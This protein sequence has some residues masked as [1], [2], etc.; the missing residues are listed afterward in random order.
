VP[1]I[2]EPIVYT[3]PPQLLSYHVA[4]LK[5]TD[6][7]QPRNLA[8]SVTVSSASRTTSSCLCLFTEFVI[9]L[10]SVLS[11]TP[12][13]APWRLTFLSRGNKSQQKK[14][15]PAKPAFGFTAR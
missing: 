6:V 5:G 11:D 15:R 8:K 3:L 2:L 10:A 14:A 9:Q 1:G 13:F 7:D 4:M 12:G